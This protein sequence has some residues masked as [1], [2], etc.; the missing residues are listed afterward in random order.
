M[1]QLGP[2]PSKSDPLPSA[3]IA[4]IIDDIGHN[5][6]R[7]MQAID[8]PASLTYA[9]IPDTRHSTGLARY[10]HRAGKEVMIHLPMAN[11]RNQPMSEI[12]LTQGLT[13]NDFLHVIDR[14]LIRVPFARG[15]NNHMGSLLTQEPEAM[16]WLM[17]SV[18]HRKMFF[19]DSRTT[20]KTVASHVARQKNVLSASRDV[21]LDNDRTLFEIDRQFRR[22]LKLARRRGTAIAIGHPYRSTLQYLTHA[23]PIL[24]QEDI[25]VISISEMIQRR[26]A[27]QQIAAKTSF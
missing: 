25:K 1:L 15:I 5:R 26:L 17:E 22:L 13:R 16:S 14:A 20:H 19:V 6:V 2:T 4:I 7:G 24:E 18:R 12:A 10:A 27:K 23:I 11:M 21:F 9:V 3:Y 8:L